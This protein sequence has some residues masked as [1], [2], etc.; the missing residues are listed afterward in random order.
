MKLKAITSALEEWAPPSLQAD[1]DNCGLICGNIDAEI[2]GVLCAL[3]CTEEVV[4][5]A[6]ER[7]C[8]LIVSHHPI[9]FKGLKKLNGSNYVER[10]LILA[11][12]HDINIYAIHTNLDHVAHGVNRKIG[13]RLGLQNL[14]ILSPTSNALLKLQTYVPETHVTTVLA[15]LFEA[16]AGHIG[17]YEQC[18]F[19]TKGVGTFKGDEQTTPFIGSPGELAK[20]EEM[21]IELILPAHKSSQVLQALRANHPYEEVAYDLLPLKNQYESIGSGMVGDMAEAV[22]FEAF[23]S[24]VASSFH[25]RA[26][27]Y[28]KATRS[29]VKRVAFCGGSGGFLLADAIASGAQVMIT[30][31]MKY[32][33]YFDAEDQ[34]VIFD[35]GHFES[36]QF[37][38]EL[39]KEHLEQN[40][41]TFA[42]LL[43][44][45]N[46]NPVQYYIS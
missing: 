6:I 38:P 10:T 32:H 41:A 39:I 8:N 46:T 18:S 44:E 31:D 2:S 36:E 25:L 7:N 27:K 17:H 19:T 1:Y 13:E 11:I 4:M 29:H 21:K 24:H 5:E 22:T 28:T 43:S 3:D 20:A 14:S 23:L 35:I 26:F 30:S 45:V 15:A 40:F 37:T 33:E 9:L 42:V 16:G 34:I 12:K